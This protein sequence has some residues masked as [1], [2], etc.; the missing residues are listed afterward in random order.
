MF[1]LQCPTARRRAPTSVFLLHNVHISWTMLT[2]DVLLSVCLS[3]CPSVRHASIISKKA[4]RSIKLFPLPGRPTILVVFFWPNVMAI[5]GRGPL[6]KAS[7]TGVWKMRAI[8]RFISSTIQDRRR[9]HETPYILSNGAISNEFEWVT[10]SELAKYS[11]TWSNARP[12][13]DSWASCYW[14]DEIINPAQRVMSS[15]SE[16]AM[17]KDQRVKNASSRILLF[18]CHPI[19]PPSPPISFSFINWPRVHHRS[20]VCGWST[21]EVR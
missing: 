9:L 1:T 16:L 5:F 12:L 14:L 18:G 13:C 15:G 2:Q 20:L 21:W 19:A 10:L 8:S 7:N 17:L 11:M 3:L 4:K 6:T